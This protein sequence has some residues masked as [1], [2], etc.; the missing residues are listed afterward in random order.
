MQF[1]EQLQH[2]NQYLM[3]RVEAP[4]L[5]LKQNANNIEEEEVIVIFCKFLNIKIKN[6]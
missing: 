5:H 1:K 4:I 2:S 6:D 3:A